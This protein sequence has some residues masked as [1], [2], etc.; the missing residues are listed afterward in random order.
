MDQLYKT[1]YTSQ[2]LALIKVIPRCHHSLGPSEAENAW[3][4]QTK[5]NIA[6][7]HNQQN[8]KRTQ[9]ILRTAQGTERPS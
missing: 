7:I 4:R 2:V 6:K 5:Q 3:P 1:W 9:C 8:Y